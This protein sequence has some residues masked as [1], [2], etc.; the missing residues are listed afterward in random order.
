MKSNLKLIVPAVL[1]ATALSA[2]GSSG[3]KSKPET[4]PT[5]TAQQSAPAPETPKTMEVNNIERT[6]EVAYK[7]GPNGTDPLNVMY[8][9][10]GDEPV[11]AQVKYQ[12]QLTPGLSR[13]VGTGNDVNGFWGEGVAWIANRA[14]YANIDKVDGDML[15]IRQ[16]TVVNGQN[17]VVD[18]IITKSC[19]LDQTATAQLNKAPA[20][21]AKGKGKAKK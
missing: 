10:Q 16:Q 13:I 8:G 4:A 6:K 17:Q 19:V 7:C 2:C 12:G 21:P 3:S 1:I 11:I 15:T 18:N 9:F 14:N 20:K 5:P